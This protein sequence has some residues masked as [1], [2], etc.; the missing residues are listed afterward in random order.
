MRRLIVKLLSYI[1][2]YLLRKKAIFRGKNYSFIKRSS[3]SL[4][5]GARREQ[6]IL[7]DNVNLYGK[8]I[9]H[10]QVGTIRLGKYVHIG[11]STQIQCVNAIEIGDYTQVGEYVVITDNNTHPTDPY[12][13]KEM[14]QIPSG[15]NMRSY[16]HSENS[17]VKI[18][19]NVW[20]GSYARVC[21]GV[22]IGDNSIVA[23][24]AIVT[25]DVPENCIV[26]GNPARIVKVDYYL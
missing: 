22:T 15:H 20:I 24:N 6:I 14:S 10:G 7:E 13:R 16:I 17:P 21:K 5:V 8:L 18:G 25:K 4:R 19:A 26:A 9:L 12:F 2:F 11:D 23:A 1:K 3:I